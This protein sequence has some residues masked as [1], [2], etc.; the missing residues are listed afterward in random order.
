MTDTSK[1]T[2]VQAVRTLVG[3]LRTAVFGNIAIDP[4]DTSAPSGTQVRRIAAYNALH[5]LAKAGRDRYCGRTDATKAGGPCILRDNHSP[6]TFD[7]RRRGDQNNIESHYTCMDPEQRDRA[8][9]Y[10][11]HSEPDPNRRA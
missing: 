6:A 4:I 8:L 9:R 11:V 3:V 7:V 5:D 2:N 10:L 1:T